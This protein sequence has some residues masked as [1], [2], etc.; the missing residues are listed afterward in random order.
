MVL[1]SS[2]ESAVNP[3]TFGILW[4]RLVATMEEQVQALMRTSFSPVVRENGDLASGLFDITGRMICQPLTGTPGHINPLSQAVKN[5]FL[6]IPPAE[7]EPGDV[8]IT[9]DPWLTT[10][11]LLDVTIGVPIFHGRQMVAFIACTCHMVDIGGYGPGTGGSDVYEEGFQIPIIYFRKQGREDTTLVRLLRQNVRDSDHFLG[12]LRAMV[13]SCMVAGRQVLALMAEYRLD[14]IQSIA[15]EILARSERAQREA[16]SS[17][18]DGSYTGALDIDGFEAPLH[19]RCTLVKSGTDITLDFDGS[20][21]E[22]SHGVNV[23]LNYTS[24]YASYAIRSALAPDVP[25]NDGSLSPIH[26]IAPEGTIVNCRRP[27]P[28]TGR[29]LV[30]MFV[31]WPVWAALAKAVPGRIPAEGAGAVWTLQMRR[32]LA[33]SDGSS[34]TLMFM[35]SG[36]TGGRP[37]KDGLSAVSFPSNIAEAPVEMW[38]RAL[39]VLIHR[40]ELR[41]DSGGPGRWRGGLGQCL[42]IGFLSPGPWL[43]NFMTDRI[44]FPAAGCYGGKAGAVGRL[45]TT[46][47]TPLPPKGRVMVQATDRV[48]LELPGGGGYGDPYSREPWRVADDV[49][50]GLVSRPGALDDY[51]V[52]LSA[53][54]EVDESTTATLREAGRA[55]DGRCPTCQESL[56]A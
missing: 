52:A 18:A 54:G 15:D 31:A 2:Y 30:G 33:E 42:E 51:G 7:M 23:V 1:M 24:G 35:V 20:S 29:H 10:G 21:L 25:N 32:K 12:D 19:L 34:E 13:A 22:S 48:V 45:S 26:V 3:V 4:D 5:I 50:G 38:E 9:N 53:D 16:I 11:Q 55:K 44:R 56:P 27:A 39:P 40:K 36:G 6:E 47:G 43:A 14:S 28:T 46:E 37:S 17:I 8:V 49:R 41:V